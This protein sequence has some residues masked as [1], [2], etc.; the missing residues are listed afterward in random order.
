ME[1]G[2]GRRELLAGAAALALAKAAAA[3]GSEAHAGH[4]SHGAKNE[5]LVTTAQ[6]CVASG[7]A[8]LNHCFAEFAEGNTELA[9]CAASVQELLAA[10]RSLVTLAA[11]DSKHLTQ[12]AAAT[13]AVCE[14]CEVECRKHEK[15][16]ALCKLCADDC[17][18]C[19]EAC[20]AH[21]AS[22]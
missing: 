14:S 11:Q 20:E 4:G 9:S 18:A 22:A 8:C 1:A 2:I 3:S 6:A 10:C 5:Q 19:I 12:F 17:K 21:A 13:R 15:M 7:E 16:H